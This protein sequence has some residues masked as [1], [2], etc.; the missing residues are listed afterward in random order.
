MVTFYIVMIV[1]RV[2]MLFAP[3]SSELAL[4]LKPQEFPVLTREGFTV[5][6]WGGSD[7]G[8]R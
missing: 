2:Y 8:S 5:L 7:L 4:T 6:E 3:C 1:L